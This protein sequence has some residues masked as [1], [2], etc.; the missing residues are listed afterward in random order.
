MTRAGRRT[1]YLTGSVVL[2]FLL[3]VIG[4]LGFFVD[5]K[6]GAA[7]GVGALMILIQF[8]FNVTLGP[9]CKSH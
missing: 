8:S 1:I 9:G 6:S 4:I 3:L 5:T 2:G 7:Y